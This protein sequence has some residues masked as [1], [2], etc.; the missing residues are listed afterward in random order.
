MTRPNTVVTPDAANSEF[1]YVVSWVSGDFI[2]NMRLGLRQKEIEIY[3]IEEARYKDQLKTSII[4]N[5]IFVF[6]RVTQKCNTHYTK[7]DY[8]FVVFPHYEKSRSLS[9]SLCVKSLALPLEEV[10]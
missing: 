6:Y 2:L 5:S 7:I 8:I 3:A 4:I 10:K 9:K 1:V